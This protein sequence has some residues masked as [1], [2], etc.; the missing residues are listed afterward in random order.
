MYRLQTLHHLL[1]RPIVFL[2]VRNM[3]MKTTPA[4]TITSLDHIV[5]TVKS[6]PKAT[7]WYVKNL[8]MESEA[9]VSASS[10]DITRY[11]LNLGVRRSI[12]MRLGR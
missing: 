2:Q 8:G 6:I 12:Y 7:E 10:P 1:Y 4:A 9:F 3:A 5:L 11:S